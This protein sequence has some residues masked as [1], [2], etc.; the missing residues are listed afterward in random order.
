MCCGSKRSALRN[1]SRVQATRQAAS[2]AVQAS[3]P[4]PF[5]P[6]TL[7]YIETSEIRVRGPMTGRLYDFSGNPPTQAVDPRDAGALA[8][9]GRFRRA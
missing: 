2:P 3:P 4:Q 1:A 7:R 6:V 8:R 5:A 9:S